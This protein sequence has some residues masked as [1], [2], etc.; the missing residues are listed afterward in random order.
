MANFYGFSMLKVFGKGLGLQKLI[1]LQNADETGKLFICCCIILNDTKWRNNKAA[2]DLFNQMF[3]LQGKFV[4]FQ[5][6]ET[7][8]CKRA[9]SF[10]PCATLR[11]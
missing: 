1:G 2:S 3:Q 9:A 7:L 5:F 4:S 8:C 11:I 10:H 6:L